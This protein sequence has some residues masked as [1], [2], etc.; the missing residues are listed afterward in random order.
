M[1]GKLAS[2]TGR[3]I[4]RRE[5]VDRT[6]IV[7]APASHIIATGSIGASHH[8][9]GAEGNGMDFIRGVGIPDDELAVL[10]GG[11]QVSPVSGPM[12]GIYLRQMALKNTPRLH[13]NSR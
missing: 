9:R 1:A 7:E 12:H 13:A 3:T 4:A 11:N 5:I 2:D 6:D 10:R 8:P